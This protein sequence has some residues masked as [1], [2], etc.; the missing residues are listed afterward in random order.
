M[1]SVC[2]CVCV[3][4]RGVFECGHMLR[5]RGEYQQSDDNI[6][7]QVCP[8]GIELRTS[9]LAAITVTPEPSHQPP[10]HLLFFE[11]STL[12]ECEPCCFLTTRLSGK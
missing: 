3:C 1:V 11:D 9:V 8:S 2:M 4:M 12:T 5:I 10:P 7:N 6:R